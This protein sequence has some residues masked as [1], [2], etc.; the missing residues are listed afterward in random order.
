MRIT[1]AICK[2]YVQGSQKK[3][4]F[5]LDEVSRVL[6]LFNRVLGRDGKAGRGGLRA[7]KIRL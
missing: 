7:N 3:L 4:T 6:L 2:E 5:S 1:I